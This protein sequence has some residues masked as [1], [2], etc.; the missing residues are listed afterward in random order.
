MK[1]GK[2]TDAL[3]QISKNYE[4]DAQ[5]SDEEAKVVSATEATENILSAR[6]PN[7]ESVCRSIRG[8][9]GSPLPRLQHSDNK[10]RGN[11]R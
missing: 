11:V 1:C 7:V 2:H 9:R 4:K 3:R 8:Y 6:E 10:T 5:E